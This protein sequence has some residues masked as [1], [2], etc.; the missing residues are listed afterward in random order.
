MFGFIFSLWGVPCFQDTPLIVPNLC[1]FV[2]QLDNHAPYLT[3]RETFE[4]AHRCRTGG[5]HESTGVKQAG[6]ASGTAVPPGNG[7]ESA[8]T[9]TSADNLNDEGITENLTI[10][11]LDLSVCADTFV[12]NESVRGVSGGQR[13]RVVSQYLYIFSRRNL[14]T[15]T[16]KLTSRVVP[17][18]R[19]LSVR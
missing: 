15:P 1:S 3:V 13:R 12:G 9:A 2:A 16:P 4:F 11:G 7:G 14:A 5:K 10:K 18:W 8:A 6:T 19:R 17:M